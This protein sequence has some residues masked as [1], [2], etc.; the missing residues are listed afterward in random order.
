M[1][2]GMCWM[3]QN[4][5][6]DIAVEG[7]FNGDEVPGDKTT[8]SV[9]YNDA[10]DGWTK[11][12]NNEINGF[13]A[14][15]NAYVA[16][17]GARVIDS[18]ATNKSGTKTIKIY[19][20]TDGAHMTEITND[21]TDLNGK[22]TR[23]STTSEMTSIYKAAYQ[24]G[25]IGNSGTFATSGATP[26]A[27]DTMPDAVTGPSQVTTMTWD[28]GEYVYNMPTNTTSCG[29]QKDGIEACAVIDTTGHKATASDPAEKRSFVDVGGQVENV[30]FPPFIT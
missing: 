4:L 29:S 15:G 20:V 7:E 17:K 21:N 2:D 3:S 12:A 13:V 10:G 27:V 16:K 30:D 19:D 6:T 28:E 5:D 25:N 11:N 22:A 23:W 9:V 18:T 24:S 1:A 14:K 26:T 8:A